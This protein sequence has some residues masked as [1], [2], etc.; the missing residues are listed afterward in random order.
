MFTHQVRRSVL[1]R[2][3]WLAHLHLPRAEEADLK[4]PAASLG[5]EHTGWAGDAEDGN[6]AW[7]LSHREDILQSPGGGRKGGREE[8]LQRE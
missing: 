7:R 3:L 5:Q 2:A 4:G 8:D 6:P 1:S